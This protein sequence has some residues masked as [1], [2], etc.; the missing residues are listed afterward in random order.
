[1]KPG[2]RFGKLVAVEIT[3]EP[4]GA[5][6]VWRLRCD[7]GRLI[8]RHHNAIRFGKLLHCGCEAPEPATTLAPT[9]TK[10]TPWTGWPSPWPPNRELTKP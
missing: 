5:Y 9:S 2:D 10:A 8:I 4:G 3:Y 6:P 7:C 1:M